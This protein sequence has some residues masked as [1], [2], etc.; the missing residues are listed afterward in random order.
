MEELV[1]R[2][3]AA[4]YDDISVAHHAVFYNIDRKDGSRLTDL[5]TMA[6]MTHQ[7]MSELIGTLV[8]L[9]YV[10]RRPDPAD[11]RARLVVLTAL[12]Q[13]AVALARREVADIDAGWV[14]RIGRG[15]IRGD[16]F[17]ALRTALEDY[18]HAR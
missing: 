14:D 11:G 15:G 8:Q 1:Q 7:S 13:E 4:G 17:V 9:G 6:G 12:G 10:E 3:G 5:A 18:D 2:L 16:L